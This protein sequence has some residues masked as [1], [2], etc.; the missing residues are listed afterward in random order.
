[1]SGV[2]KRF[3]DR[4][5]DLVT[6]H[7]PLGRKLAGRFVWVA[8][9][10]SDPTLPEG[11]EVPF[12]ATA[13]YFGMSFGGVLYVQLPEGKALSKAQKDEA[14]AFGMSIYKGSRNGP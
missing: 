14:T 1:M 6:V 7:K 2:L 10:G 11:F 8:A 13:V 12:R 4:L 9:C 5:T 3:F